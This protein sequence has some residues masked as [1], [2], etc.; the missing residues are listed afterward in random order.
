MALLQLAESPY[1][2]LAENEMYLAEQGT[3]ADNYLFIPAGLFGM[4]QDTYVRSDFFDSLSDTEFDAVIGT[5]APYQPQGLSAV[6]A[7]VTAAQFAGKAVAPAIKKA[8]EKRQ[9]KVA[10]GTA[11]QIFKPGGTLANLATKVKA[12]VEKLKNVPADQ[13]KA[14]IDKTTPVTGSLD[15]GG[16]S[17]DFGTGGTTTPTNFF[18]KYKTPLLIGGAAVA[19]LV[20]YKVFKK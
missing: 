12:G 5:L 20:L 8:I 16:T 14:L 17:I 3:V 2:M 6:G 10:S 9:E 15:I 1:N 11:K 19:G 13:T 18:T 7:V 4:D